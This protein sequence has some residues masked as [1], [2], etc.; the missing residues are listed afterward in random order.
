MKD[1][2]ALIQLDEY[3]IKLNKIRIEKN[4]IDDIIRAE[5]LGI[6]DYLYYLKKKYHNKV[7]Y[8]KQKIKRLK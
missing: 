7:K 1:Q 8:L 6:D 3:K 5:S 4:L 2:D